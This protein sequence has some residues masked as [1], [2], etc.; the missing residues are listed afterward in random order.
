MP[1]GNRN[2]VFALVATL[3]VGCI[4]GALSYSLLTN[5]FHKRKHIKPRRE[6]PMKKRESLKIQ[7]TH[8]IEF[9]VSDIASAIA[10][11]H[12]G[13]TSLELCSNRLEG[14]VSPSLGFV[15]E[16]VRVCRNLSVEVHVLVR[17][18]PGGFVYD[19]EEFEVILRDISA[20]INAGVDGN[21]LRSR[22]LSFRLSKFAPVSSC[23]QELS[24]E[25]SHLI[26]KSMKF[27]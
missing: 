19:H 18:R 24:S 26:I 27:E 14:G 4:T 16:C 9:C 8:T 2:D 25:C 11:I 12:G 13:A 10:A 3:A 21:V 15:E 17:P 23:L 5:F 6:Q 1:T 20:Y 7:Q 22:S